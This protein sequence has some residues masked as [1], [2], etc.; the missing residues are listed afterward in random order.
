MNIFLEENYRLACVATNQAFISK[1][2]A[3]LA[4]CQ[5]DE[6][7]ALQALENPKINLSLRDHKMPRPVSKEGIKGLIIRC[8][9]NGIEPPAKFKQPEMEPFD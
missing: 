4:R 3:A 2:W 9:V 5:R 6:T 1:D 8:E 7:A